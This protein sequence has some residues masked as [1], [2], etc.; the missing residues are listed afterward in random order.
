MVPELGLGSH[1]L[2]ALAG[3]SFGSPGEDDLSEPTQP[4]VD[5]ILAALPD[6]DI[7]T[8]TTGGGERMRR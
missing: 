6:R 7:A 5:P 3:N 8:S 4:F 2:P 1:F